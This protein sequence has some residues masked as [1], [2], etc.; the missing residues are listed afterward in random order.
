MP[1]THGEVP[2]IIYVPG[3]I[4]WVD[5]E[6]HHVPGHLRRWTPPL[7]FRHSDAQLDFGF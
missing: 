2:K 5:G 3:Y 4:R 7:Y 1:I 6:L